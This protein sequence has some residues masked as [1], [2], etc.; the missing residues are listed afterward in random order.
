MLATMEMMI[1]SA[2]DRIKND[3]DE[4]LYIKVRSYLSDYLIKLC[5][6]EE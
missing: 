5:N 2:A 1:D 3:E 4:G 6:I